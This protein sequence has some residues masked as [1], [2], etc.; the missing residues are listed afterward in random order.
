MK[1]ISVLPVLKWMVEK[2]MEGWAR[3]GKMDGK[4]WKGKEWFKKRAFANGK[5][6]KS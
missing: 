5:E 6:A 4:N 1:N 3:G 2:Q